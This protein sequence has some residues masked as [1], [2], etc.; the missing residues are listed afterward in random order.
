MILP[1]LFIVKLTFIFFIYFYFS[2]FATWNSTSD[3][4]KIR[5]KADMKSLRMQQ[6]SKTGNA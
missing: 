6:T 2:A 1:S 3:A 4:A 5:V